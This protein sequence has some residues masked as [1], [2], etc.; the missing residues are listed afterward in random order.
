MDSFVSSLFWTLFILGRHSLCPQIE[1]IAVDKSSS[2][3]LSS[4]S[5]QRRCRENP[6]LFFFTWLFNVA[7]CLTRKRYKKEHAIFV[8]HASTICITRPH[9]KLNKSYLKLFHR[10][11]FYFN[12]F[13]LLNN[14][15]YHEWKFIRKNY[16]VKTITIP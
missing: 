11:Y 7:L 1:S 4:Y 3:L 9:S 10:I 16:K 14:N 6:I 15:W 13:F 8:S 12:D 2:V 5:T